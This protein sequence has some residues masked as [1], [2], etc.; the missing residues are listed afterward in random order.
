M[1]N[2][3][4]IWA[5][6]IW[7]MLIDSAFLFIIGLFLAGLLHLLMNEKNIVRHLSQPGL[8]GVLKA[9]L[10][11]IPLPLCSCSVLPV[12]RQL[13]EGGASKSGVMSFLVATPESG[14]D[15]VLLTYTLT[16]P[17]LTVVRPVTAFLTAIS[18]GLS[19]TFFEKK[20]SSFTVVSVNE[21]C[22][23]NPGG[24]EKSHRMDASRPFFTRL[25]AGVRYA[26]TVMLEDLAPYLFF[27]FILAGLVGV[28]LGTDMITLPDILKTGWLGY[29]GAVIIGLPLYICATSSTPL[30]AVLLAGGFSPGAI[31]VFLMVGPATNIAS[32]VVLKKILGLGATFRYIA[33]IVMVSLICGIAVDKVYDIFDYTA[34]YRLAELES[35]QGGVAIFSAVVLSCLIIFYSLRRLVKKISYF[36]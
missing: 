3:F 7:V 17:I 28:F 9:A 1:H 35:E 15:S 13:R 2:F 8:K 18:V 29:P 23:D 12:A 24:C 14:V 19:E 25:Y 20:E 10:V 34:G 31:L 36:S 6:S 11:G 32:L 27:G 30:A 21:A 22:C 5:D 26:F 16:D 33:I 4:E